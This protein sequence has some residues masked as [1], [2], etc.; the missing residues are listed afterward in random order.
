M[1]ELI[2]GIRVFDR[3]ENQVGRFAVFRDKDDEPTIYYLSAPNNSEITLL[4]CDAQIEDDV[5]K[6]LQATIDMNIRGGNTIE[7]IDPEE[8]FYEGKAIEQVELNQDA[9]D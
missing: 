7:E 5:L 4:G 3:E 9:H 1:R 8:D 2:R 6:H